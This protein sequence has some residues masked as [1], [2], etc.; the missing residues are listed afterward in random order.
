MTRIT[1]RHGLPNRCDPTW[2]PK[3]PSPKPKTSRSARS[4]KDKKSLTWSQESR[5]TRDLPSRPSKNKSSSSKC[6][7]KELKKWLWSKRNWSR[8]IV[9]SSDSDKNRSELPRNTSMREQTIA[10]RIVRRLKFRFTKFS[11][12]IRRA[13][14]PMIMGGLPKFWHK[15]SEICV[16]P[17]K[18]ANTKPSPKL[19]TNCL[20]TK[21][22]INTPIIKQGAVATITRQWLCKKTEQVKIR[23]VMELTSLLFLGADTEVKTCLAS[24]LI[25]IITTIRQISTMCI[26]VIQACNRWCKIVPDLTTKVP[27]SNLNK[28]SVPLKT[29]SKRS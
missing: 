9:M 25:R 6:R 16:T 18:L 11:M 27:S 1:A 12:T 26:R 20:S 15:K 19:K 10:M 13:F 22:A 5:W 17:A 24:I 7:R 29:S 21:A 14:S 8:I 3:L 2:S 4:S 28:W 23:Q